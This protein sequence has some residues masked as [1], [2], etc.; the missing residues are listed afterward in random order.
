MLELIKKIMQSS[1]WLVVVKFM[2]PKYLPQREE[3]SGVIDHLNTRACYGE[4][5]D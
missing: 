3:D 5:K 2:V 4:A 1:F